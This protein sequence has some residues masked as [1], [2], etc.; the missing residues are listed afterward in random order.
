MSEVKKRVTVTLDPE[1]L[2]WA[3]RLVES[4]EARSVSAVVNDAMADKVRRQANAGILIEEDMQ[5][6]RRRDPEEFER[7]MEWA[8]E[9][10]GGPLPEREGEGADGEAAA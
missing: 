4:G 6:A 9:V 3:E 2:A 5:E 7:A 10:T 8:L 1:L